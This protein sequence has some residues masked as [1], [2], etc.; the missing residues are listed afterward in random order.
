MSSSNLLKNIISKDINIQK[1]TIQNLIKSANVEDFKELSKNSDFI[2]PFVREKI[3]NSFIKLINKNELD[4][5]FKFSTVYSLDFEDMIVKS[6]VKFANEDLTDEI[7]A[8]FE[9]G[10]LE[11]KAYCAKYFTYI[12]DTLSLEYLKEY[13]KSDYEPLKINC[14]IALCAFKDTEILNEMKNLTQSDTNDFDKLEAYKFLC[15]Y[16]T[17]ESTKAVLDSCFDSPF[18]VHIIAYL[19]DFCDFET[20]ADN[21]SVEV[22]SKIFNIL[23]EGYPEDITIETISYYRIWDF[24]NYLLNNKNPFVN[25]LLAIAKADFEEYS[26]NEN[27]HFNLDKNTKNELKEIGE[28]LKNFEPDFSKNSEMLNSPNNDYF[29]SALKVIEEYRLLDYVETL[30]NLINSHVLSSKRQAQIAQTLKSL[31]K[32]DLIQK[33][34]IANIRDNNVKV[35]IESYMN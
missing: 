18:R 24:V 11:Q 30:S 15:A 23:L 13:A 19:L 3:I 29:N 5:V 1:T 14:A 25:N 10:T 6:W 32:Q 21:F 35:L 16:N 28:L 7:L 20:L 31:N 34:T 2:F 9:A 12:K 33:E 17:I 27:Y 8:L 22:I 4:T 26:S